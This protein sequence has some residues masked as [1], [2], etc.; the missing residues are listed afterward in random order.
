M[1]KHQYSTKFRKAADKEF[2]CDVRSTVLKCPAVQ[3]RHMTMFL[4]YGSGSGISDTT[5]REAGLVTHFIYTVVYSYTHI[6]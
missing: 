4:G 2:C 6:L 1:L 3:E 5:G